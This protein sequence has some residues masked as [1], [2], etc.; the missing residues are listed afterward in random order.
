MDIQQQDPQFV[1]VEWEAYRHRI[2]YAWIGA[3][4]TGKPLL[5]F[6]HE[7]LGSVTMWKD[8]PQTLCAAV[9]CRGLVLSRWGYGQSSPRSAKEKWPVDFMQRQARAFLPAFFVAIGHDIE[10]DPPW[11]YGHSDGGSIALLFA[12]AF[13]E[14]TAGVVAVA[15]HI[16]VEDITISSIENARDGYVTTSLRSKLARYHDDPDSA[17]WGWND[18]WLNPD[19]RRWNIEAELSRIRCPV[20][21]VQGYDDEYGTLAQIRGI[22][23]A[24]LQTRLLMLHDCGHSPH[25][26]QPAAVIRAVGEFLEHQTLDMNRAV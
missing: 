5:V 24:A 6:L 26:D 4:Q 22:A 13:P 8:F 12:A 20:L 7:G 21:A 16:F 2:E 1:E 17:F 11:F 10:A 25:R 15:P 23:G 9:G 19:F 14:Q 18:I 3:H